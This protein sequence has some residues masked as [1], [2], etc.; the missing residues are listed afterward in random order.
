M[1]ANWLLL[2]KGIYDT[3]LVQTSRQSGLSVVELPFDISL[4]YLGRQDSYLGAIASSTPEID[5][6][7]EHLQSKSAAMQEA[8]ELA[9]N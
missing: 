7:F 6:H 9:K 4:E 3:K 2:G 1:I 5:V 8:V